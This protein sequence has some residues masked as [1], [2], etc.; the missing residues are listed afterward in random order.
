MTFP[1]EKRKE[2]LSHLRKAEAFLSGWII[3]ESVVSALVGTGFAASFL[4]MVLGPIVF[5]AF[6]TMLPNETFLFKEWKS[7]IFC[8][9]LLQTFGAPFA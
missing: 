1:F 3:N 2:R 7:I 9:K 4:L 6:W 8:R 5:T